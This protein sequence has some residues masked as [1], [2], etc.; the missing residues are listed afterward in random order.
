[1][2]RVAVVGCG[3]LGVPAAW[4]LAL[5]GVRQFR[6][7]DADTVERSNLHRQILYTTA[8]EGLPKATQLAATLRA[9]FGADVETVTDRVDAHNVEALLAGCEAAI[10]GTDDAVAKFVLS[11]WAI[12][13]PRARVAAIAAAIGQR[14]QWLVVT[15]TTAC[16]RCLFEAPPPPDA[17]GTCAIAG[18]LGPVTGQVGGFAARA[19]LAALAGRAD[20]AIGGLVRLSPRGLARTPVRVASDCPCQAGG[21]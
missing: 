9:R 17:V 6:L 12:V 14:G 20:P 15:P 8:D 18:V 5:G 1:M 13:Q 16:Y 19:L 7:I 4:T 11:D 10:E 3:G 21:N 2:T